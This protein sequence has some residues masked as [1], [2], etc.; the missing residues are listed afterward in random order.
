MLQHSTFSSALT[1]SRFHSGDQTNF[2]VRWSRSG[3]NNLLH[4]DRILALWWTN[5]ETLNETCEEEEDLLTTKNLTETGALSYN[6]A[7]N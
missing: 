7:M 3:S 4:C 5:I 1:L 2:E 6:R